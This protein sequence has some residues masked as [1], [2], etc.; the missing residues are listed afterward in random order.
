MKKTLL[1][2]LCLGLVF[3]MG[4]TLCACGKKADEEEKPDIKKIGEGE[5][6]F[7]L[8]V[9]KDPDNTKR[10]V[11]EVFTDEIMVQN[12][13]LEHKLIEY[14]TT[15]DGIEYISKVGGISVDYDKDKK[16]WSFQVVAETGGTHFPETDLSGF[17]IQCN[18][19][20]VFQIEQEK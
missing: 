12:A 10:D 20:Y 3:V 19:N 13:L 11:Y 2:I 18:A 5:N 8:I 9:I 15:K 7:Y 16:Y 6:N 4:L 1:R 14:S 17:D